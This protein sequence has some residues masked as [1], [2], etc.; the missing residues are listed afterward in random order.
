MK[1]SILFLAL[2]APALMSCTPVENGLPA[3]E[4]EVTNPLPEPPL[5]QIGYVLAG[6]SDLLFWGDIITPA[7]IISGGQL[8]VD[9]DGLI[10]YV[11]TDASSFPEAATATKIVCKYGIAAPGFIDGLRLMTYGGV[12]P[13]VSQ[14]ERYDHRFDWRLGMRGHTAIPFAPGVANPFDEVQQVIGGTTTTV[15]PGKPGFIRNLSTNPGGLQ[16]GD[17]G[18]DSF[19]LGDMAGYLTA[20]PKTYP[21]FPDPGVINARNLSTVLIASE[22]IDA[23]AHTEFIALSD[24]QAGLVN[25]LGTKTVLGHA[26]AL[27]AADLKKAADSGTSIAWTPRSD[28]FLYG[29]TLQAPLFHR[30]GGNIIL[31]SVWNVTGSVNML[32][33][34]KAAYSFSETYLNHYFSAKDILDMAT[35][36]AAKAFH[37]D[38]SIGSIRQGLLADLV[39]YDTRA[40]SGYLAVINAAPVDVALVLRAGKVLYG[41][42]YM[43]ASLPSGDTG[44][45]TI[46]FGSNTKAI[47][48]T[49]EVGTTLGTL[50]AGVSYQLQQIASPTNEPSAV[51]QRPGEYTGARTENDRDGD[52]IANAVDNAPDCFN[53]VRPMDGGVQPDADGDGIGDAADPTPFG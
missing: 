26:I 6:D 36:N 32:R 4:S 42:V 2:C 27:T 8:L 13:Y 48:T 40:R 5:K 49:R 41:D 24:S 31:G 28:L 47:Y 7:G 12:S 19:P 17:A 53:P 33:E 15:Q 9:G 30:L 25:V 18:F 43:A 20:N 1:K 16:Y 44:Y 23:E 37:V 45:E 22:G 29:N 34:V 51:P 46:D 14:G 11:G 10:L 52:G 35:V 21:G 39:I 50:S 3:P 38:G